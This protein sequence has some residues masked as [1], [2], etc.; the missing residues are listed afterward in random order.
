M[1]DRPW[2]PWAAVFTFVLAAQLALVAAAGTDVPYLDQWDVEGRQIYPAW[3][4]GTWRPSD[5]LRPH[6]EHR[7]IWTRALDVALFAANGGWDPLVQQAAGAVLRAAAAALLA[8]RLAWN[9]GRVGRWLA[10]GGIAVAFLPHLAWQ[11]ALWGFQ[12]HVYFALLFAFAAFALLE[13]DEITPGRQLAG[14][15]MGIA[16]ACAMGAGLLVPWALLGLVALRA[17]GRGRVDRALAREAW[18]A[19]VLL[20][21]SLVVRPGTAANAGLHPATAGQFLA[22]LAQAAAWP[23]VWTPVAAAGLNLPVMVAVAGRLALRRRAALGEDFVLLLAGWALALAAAMAWTRAGGGEFDGGVP[24][25]YAD[26]L[27]LLP[28]ANLWCAV[29]LVR[30]SAAAR[31]P[32]YRVAAGAWAALLLLGWA[33]LSGEVMQRLILPRV[34]DRDAPLRVMAAFQ[35]TNDPAVFTGQ[36]RLYVPHPDPAVIR[37]V[38]SDPRLQGKLPP[39]LQPGEPLGPLSRAV[40]WL[41]AR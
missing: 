13:G 23:H 6:S 41:L 14:V 2:F 20:G 17:A 25:R 21:V 35:R 30:E 10:A 8:W 40:R 16:A 33:G 34:R 11:N 27:V 18:P 36:P 7:I 5:L 28:V 26:F 1:S 4:D 32:A 31:R 38:I 19:L 12:S 39:S 3:V 29:A 37:A 15:V 22:A 24:S 9:A